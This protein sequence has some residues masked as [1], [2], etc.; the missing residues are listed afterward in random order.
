MIVSVQLI[1]SLIDILT[2]VSKKSR[3]AQ[4]AIER[5]SLRKLFERLHR[6]YIAEGVIYNVCMAKS[7]TDT[8][9]NLQVSS[10]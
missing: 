7:V 9:W 5:V 6:T 2:I 4:M 1:V 3:E 10:I 8:S